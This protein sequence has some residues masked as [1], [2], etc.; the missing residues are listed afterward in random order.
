[1]SENQTKHT[2]D[3]NTWIDKYADYL[4]NYAVTRGK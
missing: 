4:F 3:P 1:M 2:L